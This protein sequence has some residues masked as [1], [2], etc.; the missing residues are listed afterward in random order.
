MNRFVSK[1]VNIL[2]IEISKYTHCVS[3]VDKF[4]VHNFLNN[5]QQRY[6]L[7]K[8]HSVLPKMLYL[9]CVVIKLVGTSLLNLSP[10][11]HAD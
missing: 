10:F 7:G 3:L 6:A 9:A 11:F 8:S 1:C 5:K 2:K 4:D